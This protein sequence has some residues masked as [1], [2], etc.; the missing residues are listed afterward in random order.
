M[1]TRTA[2]AF[3]PKNADLSAPS[4][5]GTAPPPMRK[6]PLPMED[7]EPLDDMPASNGM[8]G[9]VTPEAL[10]YHDGEQ[11]CDACSH[12]GRSNNCAVLQMPVEP[13]GGCNA[14]RG[15]ADDEEQ[16]DL[17]EDDETA[18]GE[19]DEDEEDVAPAGPRG[20]YGS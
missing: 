8:T 17:G 5:L 16:E 14:F 12:F 19:E 4:D 3:L 7:E 15:S 2:P 1:A 11:R 9:K 6:P 18:W 10:H 13:E 20:G